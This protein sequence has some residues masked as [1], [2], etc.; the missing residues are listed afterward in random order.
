MGDHSFKM[1]QPRH[2]YILVQTLRYLKSLQIQGKPHKY[3]KKKH[4]KYNLNEG[5]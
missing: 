3:L 4:A 1:Q 5:R 2:L